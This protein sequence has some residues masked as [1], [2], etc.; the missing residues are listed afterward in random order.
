MNIERLPDRKETVIIK[1]VKVDDV[2]FT[3]AK[4]IYSLLKELE[5]VDGFFN[6]VTIHDTEMKQGLIKLGIIYENVRGSCAPKNK[7]KLKELK[8]KV[9]D[10]VCGDD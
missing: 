5:D 7:T 10:I 4:K 6:A 2:I 9:L 3:N 8:D 1:Q